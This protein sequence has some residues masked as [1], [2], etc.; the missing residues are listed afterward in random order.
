[1]GSCGQVHVAVATSTCADDGH[2]GCKGLWGDAGGSTCVLPPEIGKRL[3]T[4]SPSAYLKAPFQA[5]PAPLPSCMPLIYATLFFVQC[6]NACHWVTLLCYF[7]Y[8]HTPP[9]QGGWRV[10][11]TCP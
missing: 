8:F 5:R 11:R 2:C 1:M 10:V 6:R 3:P 9:G 4:H 7:L